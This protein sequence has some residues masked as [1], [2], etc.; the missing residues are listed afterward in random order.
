MDRADIR[1]HWKSWAQAHGTHFKATT[2]GRTA[3]LL[4]LDALRRR[5]EL[6]FGDNPFSALEVGCG[7]GINCIEMARAFA[8]ANLDG[9]DYV[10]EMVDAAQESARS[11]AVQ[12]R[13]RFFVG[14]VTRLRDLAELHGTY[15]AVITDRCLINLNTAEL[16]GRAIGDLAQKLARGGTLLMIENSLYT[17]GRQNAAR[18]AVG[19]EPRTPAEFNRFFSEEEMAAH[20][21]EASLKLVEIEDFSS[22]H[23]LVL[24]ALVPS[25]NGGEVDY[26]HPLVAA[27]AEISSGFSAGER[28]AFGAFGQNRLYVCRKV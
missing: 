18:E 1:D 2:R 5:L 4:E 27:A 3:K 14:D 19:L 8:G 20:I 10:P 24:Y 22:L 15:D 7:N 9:V 12:D 23:D 6:L 28:S 25:I 21:A 11:A 26:E 17:Y 16:Q 13:T